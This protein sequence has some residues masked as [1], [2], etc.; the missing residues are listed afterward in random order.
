MLASSHLTPHTSLLP[1]R[2]GG[3]GSGVGWQGGEGQVN[4]APLPGSQDIDIV[5]PRT[6]SDSDKSRCSETLLSCHDCFPRTHR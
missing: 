5:W 1:V 2:S 4:P 6:C 3:G